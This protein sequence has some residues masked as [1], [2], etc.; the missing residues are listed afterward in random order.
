VHCIRIYVILTDVV[1]SLHAK[2]VNWVAGLLL[3]AFDYKQCTITILF[4]MKDSH[5]HVTLKDVRY[6]ICNDAYFIHVPLFIDPYFI[7]RN[8]IT[9]SSVFSNT[10]YQ[11]H[12]PSPF[13][14]LARRKHIDEYMKK[15]TYI[16][17]YTCRWDVPNIKRHNSL[18]LLLIKKNI[19]IRIIEN[20]NRSHNKKE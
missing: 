7:G 10:Y 4:R 2:M 20:M 15:E 16:S 6:N 12:L 1:W 11:M 17:I 14:L 5:P 9:F 13:S 3:W 18:L 8:L 19:R